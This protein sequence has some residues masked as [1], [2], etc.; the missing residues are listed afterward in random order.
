MIDS[1]MI[2]KATFEK[3]IESINIGIFDLLHTGV[4]LFCDK[5]FFIYCNKSF[6]KMYNLPESVIGKHI[7]DY[8]L[9]GERGV[10]SSIRTRKMVICSSQTKNNVWGVS[11]RYPI[12]DEQGQ[13]RGVVVE[14]IP[15][16]LDK[17]KLLAL[18]DT[19]R[20]LEMKSY[21]FSEQKEAHKNSGLYTFEAIVGEAPCIENMRCLGRRFAFSQEPIL[22][23]GES[24][25]GKEL[26][27]QALH[28]ASQRSD[29]PF[30][31]VN[32]AALPPELME[33]ELFGYE[34]G[35][36]TGAKVGGVKG[37]FEMA[38]TGTI[39]LDEIGEL[40]LPMQAKLLR[41]LETGEIQKIAHKGQLHSD[42][43]LIGATN[44]NLAEMVRQGQFR[45]DL[46]HRLSVFELDIP[47]LR[48]RVS[49]IPLLVRHFVT[50]SVGDNRQK[51]IR[52]DDALY[53]AFA[54]YPWRGN[55]RELKN[56]LVYALYSLGDDQSVLTVQHLPPRFMRELEA[57]AGTIPDAE[58]SRQD[59]QNFSEASARAERKVLWDALVNSRYNKV[60][61]ARTLG[62]SRSKLYRKLREHGLLAKFEAQ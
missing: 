1:S 51:D 42:F 30:V 46:Y 41:V 50:Q 6:L 8:F 47:P 39:F 40:P 31:T 32:C 60:L 59:S 2:L 12:Q 27:A 13:L 21:S 14:S 22:V 62:I 10:M 11:F 18:L 3:I 58:D 29:R 57:V 19:V 43:R 36:F 7:T 52:I 25:T 24:G 44:R 23:C 55:V 16:N 5:G 28:M 38:D 37:K 61:A 48:D 49:D 34:T 20:N 53:D 33:S 9:T 35:A 54:Q 15:S 4:A 26:V 45:E 56:V 17:D